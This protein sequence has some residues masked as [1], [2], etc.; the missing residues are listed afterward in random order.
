MYDKRFMHEPSIRVPMMIRY[1]RV[2]QP[3]RVVN[4]M[5]LNIDIA[6]TLLELAGVPIPQ[7]I[8]GKSM[9][10]LG[11]GKETSWRKDWLYEY[12]EYPGSQQVKPNRGIRTEHYKLIH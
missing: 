2:F 10:N 11:T 4:E 3:G 9:V 1:P 5:A 12:Y 7:R 8:Q 6:P